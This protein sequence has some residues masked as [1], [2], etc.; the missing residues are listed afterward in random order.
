MTMRERMLAFVQGR[1]HDRVP[2][3]QY[4]GIAAPNDEIWATVGREQMGLLSWTGLHSF[5]TP[6]CRFEREEI[7]RDGRPGF[8]STLHTP[9][10]SLFEERFY[11]PTY[12]TSAAGCHYVKEPEDYKVLMA[13]FRDLEVQRDLNGFNE[14]LQ[15]LGNDGL[16]HTAV[17]RTPYQQL[18]VQWVSLEDLCIH[19]AM[20]PEIM[21]EMIALMEAVQRRTFEVVRDAVSEGIPLPYI[22]VPDNITA[23]AIGEAYFRRYC[24][25]A[26]NELAAMLAEMGQDI[27]VYVHADGDLKA[28]WKAFADTAVRGL[29]SMSPPPD[30]DT[31]VA[32]AMEQWPD[33]RV[34][35]NF[36]S[37]VHLAAEE[38]VFRCT[39]RILEEGGRTGR[40]QIQISENV[41]PGV[42]KNS[43]PQIIRAVREF[44]QISSE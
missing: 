9:E 28:L 43:Y 11:E 14:T 13:Y 12:N 33:M 20:Y 10:G 29:D 26:Y 34:C 41:P 1:P 2:F 40:L 4:S 30:N 8:R 15:A 31:R 21:E 27:P 37:S 36:P 16:P 44:G 3:V 42:W 24:L 17:T 32:D 19:L 38:E 22:V 23:P 5:V 18:W 25:P 7:T 35:I 39:Q 6:K